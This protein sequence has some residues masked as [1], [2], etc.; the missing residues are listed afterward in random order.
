LDPGYWAGVEATLS[1]VF[2]TTGGK[3]FLAKN[4]RFFRADYCVAVQNILSEADSTEN[5]SHDDDAG[6]QK[7]VDSP[8]QTS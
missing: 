1:Y 2:T 6:N 4:S 3:R 5:T 7:N 8:I